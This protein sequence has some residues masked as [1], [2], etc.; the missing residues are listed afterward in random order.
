MKKLEEVAGTQ[1]VVH[2][3]IEIELTKEGPNL[4]S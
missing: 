1:L 4:L 3:E 2:E